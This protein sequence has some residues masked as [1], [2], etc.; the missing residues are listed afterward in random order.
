M[1]WFGSERSVGYCYYWIIGLILWVVGS[2]GYVRGWLGG[3]VMV[4]FV[5]GGR[6]VLIGLWCGLEC[7]YKVWVF[8]LLVVVSGVGLVIVLVGCGVD[9]YFGCSICWGV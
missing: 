3:I 7:S 5:W 9:V 1:G 4:C 8:P 2:W 6:F